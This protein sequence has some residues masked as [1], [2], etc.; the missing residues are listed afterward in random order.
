MKR[1]LFI[2][3]ILVLF[4]SMCVVADEADTSETGAWRRSF[5]TDEF[6]DLTEEFKALNRYWHHKKAIISKWFKEE[7]FIEKYVIHLY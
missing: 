1:F 2:F 7:Y 3:M 4:S 6:G 5:L